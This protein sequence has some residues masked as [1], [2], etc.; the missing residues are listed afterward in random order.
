MHGGQHWIAKLQ[1]R[2]DAPNS[3]LRE[4]L[5]MKSARAC[6]VDAAAVEFCRAGPHQV[7]VVKRFDRLVRDDHQV[8]RHGFASAHTMLRL[9]STA[10]RGDP[11]R[12]YPYLA[13]ELQRWCG[14]DGADVPAMKREL[15]RRM[16]FNA[17]CGSGDDHPRNHGVLC[18]G[19]RWSLSPAYDIAPTITF[20]ESL[21]M[22]LTREGH[23]QAARWALLRDCE[24]FGYNED[25]CGRHID[26]A[27]LAMKQA[28][29]AERTALAFREDDAPTPTPAKWLEA[30]PPENLTPKR[31]P[32]ARRRG[33][34]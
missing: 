20:S 27:T 24:T 28:W 11:Q 18:V 5:A 16:V 7:V 1:E 3:P 26:Q 8:L 29:E 4:Y 15:W 14:A 23:M 33:S 31:R 30:K 17:I 21:A 32:R 2:G 9:D 19:G 10:T 13:A 25:E 34:T 12:S 22:S 6:G